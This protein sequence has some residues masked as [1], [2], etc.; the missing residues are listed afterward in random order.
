[1]PDV[2]VFGEY[3]L[4]GCNL[5]D[6]HNFFAHEE[7]LRQ[8][9]LYVYIITDHAH[10]AKSRSGIS[11][12]SGVHQALRAPLFLASLIC[13]V[14]DTLLWEQLH[15][16]FVYINVERLLAAAGLLVQKVA[17]LP[18]SNRLLRSG[19]PPKLYIKLLPV[20]NS[21]CCEFTK[22]GPKT[23]A[24]TR[25]VFLI[26]CRM[27]LYRKTRTTFTFEGRPGRGLVLHVLLWYH[28]A[29]SYT[30]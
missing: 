6:R 20:F 8:D 23:E 14:T 9:P 29:A 1:M 2:N 22:R 24:T 4:D 3:L 25:S 15:T 11:S 16:R 12:G 19:V 28:F 21:K 17:P 26:R 10:I 27:A 13:K 7:H 5:L 18:R 30:T